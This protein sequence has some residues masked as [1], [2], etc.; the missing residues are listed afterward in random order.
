[1]KMISGLAC[2]VFLFWGEKLSAQSDA[3]L[4]SESGINFPEYYRLANTSAANLSDD[5][6]IV[7]IMNIGEEIIIDGRADQ[8]WESI[9]SNP[10]THMID[11]NDYPLTEDCSGYF[12]AFWAR[13]SLFVLIHAIDDITGNNADNPWENDGYEIY[14]DLDNSKDE[15]YKEDNYQ[16]RFN[17]NSNDITGREGLNDW[18]P[19]A[20]DFAIFI[21][22]GEYRNLEV[23]F[24]L[25]SL[26]MQKPTGNQLMGFDCQILD[27]DGAGR[28][29]ALAWNNNQHEAWFNPSMMGTVELVG[30]STIREE[31]YR[32]K[33]ICYPNPVSDV[34]IIEAL[35]P[36]NKVSIFSVK[37]QLQLEKTGFTNGRVI[38][39]LQ[40]LSAGYKLIKIVFE[41]R[42]TKTMKVNVVN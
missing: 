7:Q 36:M 14:L 23:V 37:G 2:I 11:G 1:M 8:T 22:E 3:H 24:P 31:I 30:G 35:M 33:I 18:S 34:L 25:L 10:I 27:N 17:V 15:E 13:D 32:D 5:T 16:F 26:G 28:E 21:E 40:H 41:D 38:L 19:P 20:V 29:A 4:F 6:T 12:K 9:P 42:S 39:N